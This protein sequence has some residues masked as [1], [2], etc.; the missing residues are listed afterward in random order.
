MIITIFYWQN[1]NCL[2]FKLLL[3]VKGYNFILDLQKKKT[4]KFTRKCVLYC[5][6]KYV[7]RIVLVSILE[8]NNHNA[9]KFYQRCDYNIGSR[10]LMNKMVYFYELLYTIN[11][12]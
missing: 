3:N 8:H 7:K 5:L 6:C 4:W 1:K 12:Y 11:Y 10:Y 2:T 9:D